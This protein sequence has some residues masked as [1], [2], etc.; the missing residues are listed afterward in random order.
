MY[1]VI[2]D[3][4]AFETEY[5]VVGIA[6]LIRRTLPVN[7]ISIAHGPRSYEA[8]SWRLRISL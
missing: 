1:R 8:A 2:P 3:P 6:L 5:K 4:V 7:G